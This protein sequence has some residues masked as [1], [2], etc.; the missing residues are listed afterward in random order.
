MILTYHIYFYTNWGPGA[1]KR[2]VTKNASLSNSNMTV[3][4][5]K[6]SMMNQY[7]LMAFMVALFLLIILLPALVGYFFAK[8][9]SGLRGNFIWPNKG[10]LLILSAFIFLASTNIYIFLNAGPMPTAVI[11]HNFINSVLT[12]DTACLLQLTALL[13]VSSR[14]TWFIRYADRNRQSTTSANIKN[15]LREYENISNGIGPLYAVEFSIHAPMILCFAY[16]AMT[17]SSLLLVSCTNIVWSSLILIHICLISEDCHD[18]VQDL[19][20]AIRYI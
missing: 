19:V 7:I 9:G 1:P 13:L 4:S 18:A 5:P 20:P 3:I 16:F 6:K 15:L 12:F 10:W 8:N 11:V 2:N 17:N 14:Q